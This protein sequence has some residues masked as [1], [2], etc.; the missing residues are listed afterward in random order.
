MEPQ[1]NGEKQYRAFHDDCLTG[2]TLAYAQPWASAWG[3]HGIKT[4]PRWCSPQVAPGAW[5]AFREGD[6]LKGDYAFL[7]HR[8]PDQSRGVKNAGPDDERFGA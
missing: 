2:K 8:Q 7:M 4:A 6:T 5:V 1:P 3:H